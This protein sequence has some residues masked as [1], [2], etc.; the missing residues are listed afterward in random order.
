MYTTTMDASPPTRTQKMPIISISA[1]IL[2]LTRNILYFLHNLAAATSSTL[3]LSSTVCATI[4]QRPNAFMPFG[5]CLVYWDGYVFYLYL[6]V[7]MYAF[8]STSL[9]GWV[10]AEIFRLCGVCIPVC[11]TTEAGGKKTEKRGDIPTM[12]DGNCCLSRACSCR[13]CRQ[14][15]REQV[16][17]DLFIA[18]FPF[19]LTC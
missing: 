10:R 3:L 18:A 11:A 13:K 5:K 2:G 1:F 6:C 7:F 16:S 9:G 17:K 8:H 15:G 4:T 19:P 14:R 12:E